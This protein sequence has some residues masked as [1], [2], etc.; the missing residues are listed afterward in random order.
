MGLFLFVSSA[1]I[2]IVHNLSATLLQL[3]SARADLANV[4][5]ELEKRVVVRTDELTRANEQLIREGAAREAAEAQARQS[6]KVEA[7]GKLTGG[8]A[9]DFNNMLAIFNGNLDLGKRRIATG[10]TDVVKHLDNA[11]DGAKRSTEVTRRL[12]AFSHQQPLAPAIIDTNVLV[13]GMEDL[14]PRTLSER[15]DFEFV[16]AGGLWR[17]KIDPRQ[18]ESAILNLAVNARDAIPSGGRLTIE[19][20]ML[21]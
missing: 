5:D 15:I 20:M 9:H 10:G 12:L 11:M 17:T 1:I 21:G 19:T 4:N 8:V 7:I 16:L 18:I 6:Q 13:R 2:I 14:L 3:N